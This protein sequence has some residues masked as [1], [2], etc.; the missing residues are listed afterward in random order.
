MNCQEAIERLPWWLNGSLESVERREVE[1]HLAGCAPCREA[2]AETRLTWEIYAQHIPSEALVA[3]AFD[4][5]PEGVDPALVERH[6]AECPQCAA[7]LELV[8]SSRLLG[9][10]DE[11][12]ILPR[13]EAPG[14]LVRPERGWQAATLA[15]GLTGLIAIGGWVAN[16]RQVQNLEQAAA[17][18]TPQV[19]TA[20]GATAVSG[21]YV[22]FEPSTRATSEEV[23]EIR[24]SD[25][26]AGLTF[27]PTS[28]DVY[29]EHTFKLSRAGVDLVPE[30]PLKPPNDGVYSVFLQL[31]SLPPGDYVLS[32][33][34]TDD[35]AHVE[36]DSHRFR[37]VP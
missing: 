29:H 24:K 26:T 3:Y 37:L 16:V 4:E 1:E 8:R 28:R 6:L 35:R 18:R 15:A 31:A 20:A 9:E 32:I 11:V 23:R 25:G 33:F 2:L 22:Y 13:R 34:G 5:R 17:A 19:Q 10:H 12:A 30:T 36:V 27:N 7:E 14:R 21:K